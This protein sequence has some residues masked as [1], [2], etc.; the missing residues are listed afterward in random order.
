MNARSRITV[1]AAAGAVALAAGIPV[2]GFTALPHTELADGTVVSVDPGGRN[3]L[4]HDTGGAAA[5]R[6]Q[7]VLIYVPARQPVAVQPGSLPVTALQ[8]GDQVQAS[9]G[10]RSHWAHWIVLNR[11]ARTR[12]CTARPSGCVR[13]H[14]ANSQSPMWRSHEP[15]PSDLAS[16]DRTMQL[17]TTASGTLQPA[18]LANLSATAPF[19][20]R[21]PWQKGSE[22]GDPLVA[23]AH[24]GT[25][26]RQH[27]NPAGSTTCPQP[28]THC[29]HN[30]CA[31]GHHR[32]GAGVDRRAG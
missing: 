25:S 18:Q 4:L 28:R 17:T 15:A 1:L 8:P 31:A 30:R 20:H 11:V 22:R 12:A 24:P 27:L 26:R 21:F 19:R 6:G 13:R 2:L 7:D 14:A 5:L 29:H 32:R 16:Q 9:I 10:D 23:G 3:L